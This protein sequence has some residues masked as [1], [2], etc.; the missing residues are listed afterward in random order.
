MN[1][2]KA[3]NNRILIIIVVAGLLILVHG[4]SVGR[5]TGEGLNAIQQPLPLSAAISD[6][7]EDG[8]IAPFSGTWSTVVGGKTGVFSAKSALIS[9]NQRS[10]IVLS[11]NVPSDGFINFARKVSSEKSAVT[12][13]GATGDYLRFYID[14]VKIDEWA[15]EYNWAYATYP[16]TKGQHTFMWSYQK[17]IS[18]SDGLDAAWIDDVVIEAAVNTVSYYDGF[19][20]GRLIHFS[21]SGAGGWWVVNNDKY[22]GTYSVRASSYA[23]TYDDVS[24]LT[25]SCL[26]FPNG[27]KV[28]FALKT[29][30][31]CSYDR[32]SFGI[33]PLNLASWGP[34]EPWQ[35]KTVN[36]P[37]GLWELSWRWDK[38]YSCPFYGTPNG[39]AWV[40]EI[41][42]EGIMANPPDP[43]I[44][45]PFVTCQPF[46]P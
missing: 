34:N 42:I 25:L 10:D 31:Q 6:G 19:E 40:D 43:K 35:T 8:N 41:K 4:S 37:P 28:T 45:F 2:I 36:I 12:D 9:D 16:V 23:S 38:D 46:N 26:W 32:L 33:P 7:F 27:G 39:N 21:S 3:N 17:D 18:R 13:L 11:F 15:G 5:F 14:G 20:S 24:Y 1:R 29:S 44:Y 30:S 22:S